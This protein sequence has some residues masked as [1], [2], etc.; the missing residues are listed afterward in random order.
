MEI[1]CHIKTKSYSTG[2]E[3]VVLFTQATEA[4]DQLVY[5]LR[6]DIDDVKTTAKEALMAFGKKSFIE[7]KW[8]LNKHKYHAM[9]LLLETWHIYNC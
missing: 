3:S 9:G 8:A 5:L 2:W 4:L 6:C 1:V 7:P